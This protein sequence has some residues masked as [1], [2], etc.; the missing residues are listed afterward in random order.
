M[1]NRTSKA[2]VTMAACCGALIAPAAA[3]AHIS[4][5]P[6]TIPA[7]AF[8]TLDVRVPGEQE[9]AY[10]YRVDMLMPPGFTEVAT[11]NVPGW[12]VRKVM[13]KLAKPI[14]TDEGPIDEEV[15]RTTGN[16][17]P[18]VKKTL[19]RLTEEHIIKR[20]ATP[21]LDRVQ[22]PDAEREMTWAW[23]VKGECWP[24]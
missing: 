11:Q 2:I 13:A 6:N 17:L 7:G 16:G 21:A 8:V 12:S 14:Q 4:L 18:Y 19:D 9:G 10:A 24:Q 1:I 3:Q 22:T 20:C 23:Y 5:H 15:S